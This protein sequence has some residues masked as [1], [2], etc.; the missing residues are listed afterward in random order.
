MVSCLSYIV[1]PQPERA[2]STLYT[3]RRSHCGSRTAK[4]FSSLPPKPPSSRASKVK[5]GCPSLS[6]SQVGTVLY[7]AKGSLC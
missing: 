5:Q 7:L 3:H 1:H 4:L 6:V 2:R